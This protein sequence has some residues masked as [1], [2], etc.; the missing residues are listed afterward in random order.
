MSMSG[1]KSSS[2]PKDMTPE[3]FK[4]LQG[5]FASVIGNLIGQYVPE[6]TEAIMEG[7]KGPT[8]TAPSANETATLNQLQQAS[9]AT[10]APGTTAPD[11]SGVTAAG[12]D[13]TA[14]GQTANQLGQTAAGG[15]GAFTDAL[16]SGTATGAFGGTADNPFLQ[17]YVQSAQR[18]TQQALEESLG[19]T[20][21]G[22]FAMAG[23]QT[24]PGGSSAFDRAAA[25]A[26]RGAAD[27][28]GDIATNINYQAYEAAAG[29]EADAVNS[30]L[31]RRGQTA[32]SAMDRAVTAG[33]T[34]SQI[35]TQEVDNLVKNL[36]AQALPRMIEDLG[37]ERGMEAFNQRVNA[38]LSTLG[39]GAGVTR[40]VISSESKSSSKGFGL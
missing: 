7:Y 27:S 18:Q 20:L 33:Q 1:S 4:N 35:Q 39:I 3:E 2:K 25:I 12:A 32:N 15:M 13:P 34:Q 38:L 29:R 24:Q 16:R 6:G 31:Q 17:S 8:T 37:I 26:T 30:E 10:G 5:P 19:R 22:R 36:Q 9:G 40:P 14:A 28:L 23:H 21:P 11:L